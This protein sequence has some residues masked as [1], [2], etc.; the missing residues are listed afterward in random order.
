M[1]SIAT[2]ARFINGL[3][4]SRRDR[5]SSHRNAHRITQRARNTPKSRGLQSPDRKIKLPNEK[6]KNCPGT[7]VPGSL[8]FSFWRF[9]FVFHCIFRIHPKNKRVVLIFH[10]FDS[11]V[12]CLFVE[13]V[14]YRTGVG[15]PGSLAEFLTERQ[16]GSPFENLEYFCLAHLAPKHCDKMKM[17]R[18]DCNNDEPA[19]EFNDNVLPTFENGFCMVRIEEHGRFLHG[20]SGRLFQRPGR[21]I[22]RRAIDIV[23]ADITARV[24]RQP[25]AIHRRCHK[26]V[27]P[28]R[29]IKSHDR[30][31]H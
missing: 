18:H 10:V 4:R 13:T 25:M 5:R 2:P 12:E 3:G 29:R 23:L 20:L 30:F 14:T 8:G 16:T 17:I 21:D 28:L 26:H 9:S 31:P 27:S 1:R 19:V 22:K 24:P 7:E 11:R 6:E 15:P